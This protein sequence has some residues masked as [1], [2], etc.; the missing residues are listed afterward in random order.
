MSETISPNTTIITRLSK[1]GEG[2]PGEVYLAY[3][4]KLSRKVALKLLPTEVSS[5]AY[6]LRRSKP[7]RKP[8]SAT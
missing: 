2:G 3:D 6:R 7:L 4:S 8:E 1:L 5:D